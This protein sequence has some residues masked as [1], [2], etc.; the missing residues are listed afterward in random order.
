L[1][2]RA[3]LAVNVKDEVAWKIMTDY[4]EKEKSKQIG[5]VET[6]KQVEK[7]VEKEEREKNEAV[8]KEKADPSE[9]GL[10]KC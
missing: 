6:R 1:D 9:L 10:E 3:L 8:E 2:G 4:A 7:R 5:M